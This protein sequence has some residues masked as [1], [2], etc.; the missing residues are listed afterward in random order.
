MMKNE[1]VPTAE[2]R[3]C[4]PL[5]QEFCQG[6]GLEIGAAS[7]SDFGVDA[8]NLD[9]TPEPLPAYRTEQMRYNGGVSPIH[10]VGFGE[11]LPIGSNSQ[12][13]L[14]ASHVLEHTPDPIGTLVEWDRVIRPG[15]VLFLI[16]PHKERTPDRVRPRTALAHV[17]EDYYTKQTPTTHRETD[18]FLTPPALHTPHYHA[19]ITVDFLEVVVWMIE[20]ELVTWRL[21]EIE[22]IDS[23]R[24][25]GF[26]FVLRKQTETLPRDLAGTWVS[27]RALRSMLRCP[28]QL[29]LLKSKGLIVDHD[30]FE[31]L[32]GSI[33]WQDILIQERERIIKS[34]EWE[35]S[36]LRRD[37]DGV[38]VW[39][40]EMEG[41]L[42]V[43]T[44][45]AV[46]VPAFEWLRARFTD[47]RRRRTPDDA[48]L[49]EPPAAPRDTDSEQ[50]AVPPAPLDEAHFEHFVAERQARL[51]QASL[52]WGSYEVEMT[53][54]EL[55]DVQGRVVSGIRSGEPLTV[56]MQ[57]VSHQPIPD[58]V[59]G[60]AIH[61]QG[62]VQ[63][64]G[65][66][67]AFSKITMPQ[68]EGQGLVECAFESLPLLA[69]QY[70]IS[71]SVYDSNLEHAY[72]HQH[73]V[74]P[75]AVI[76][77][78]AVEQYGLVVL[79]HRWMVQPALAVDQT[80][81]FEL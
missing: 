9:L 54:I 44:D 33:I 20:Q 73:F 71:C 56:R 4:M 29:G 70:S 36:E 21:E 10:I 39:A 61:Y 40:R 2:R 50:V 65:I 26:T 75:F 6:R 78:H 79:P 59:F 58:P 30:L 16:I 63:V 46:Y 76:G 60:I 38:R 53:S 22:D 55:I 34:H 19:W 7:Y 69:G 48:M 77:D 12:D 15:G 74:A 17:I 32:A 57:Y 13:F 67:T 64:L 49:Q 11:A 24:Q 37:L 42:R 25:S 66:N 14:L 27:R 45:K 31:V 68:I 18:G 51:Y 72:D 41:R 5:A 35:I 8:W 23:D 28:E 81:G 1:T 43:V 52:R 62:G 47:L 80:I 3:T